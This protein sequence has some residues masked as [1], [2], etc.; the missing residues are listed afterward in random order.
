MKR[1]TLRI[2]NEENYNKFLEICKM[3]NTS[4]NSEVE[5]FIEDSLKNYEKQIMIISEEV[6]EFS[7][8]FVSMSKQELIEEN[9]NAIL[10][11]PTILYKNNNEIGIELKKIFKEICSNNDIPYPKFLNFNYK[12]YENRFK[13][14][15]K[16]FINLFYSLLLKEYDNQKLN[17]GGKK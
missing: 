9:I 13:V 8:K 11:I 10:K 12:E 15:Y 5:K 4:F 14:L 7:K 6:G 1:T 2:Y 17:F 3:K 16:D